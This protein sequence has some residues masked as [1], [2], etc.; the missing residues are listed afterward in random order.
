MSCSKLAPVLPL[1]LWGHAASLCDSAAALAALARTTRA[2]NRALASPRAWTAAR[3]RGEDE[4]RRW[5]EEHLGRLE[6]AI[7]A[8]PLLARVR[9]STEHALALC[10]T[11]NPASAERALERGLVEAAAAALAACA[12]EDALTYVHALR[13]LIDR[14]GDPVRLRMAAAGASGTAARKLE[15]ADPRARHAGAAL[16]ALAMPR[17]SDEEPGAPISEPVLESVLAAFER[18]DDWTRI[19]CALVLTRLAFSMPLEIVAGCDRLLSMLGSQA[20]PCTC[21]Q[22]LGCVRNSIL[23]TIVLAMLGDAEVRARA[24]RPPILRRM[25][26]TK[27]R[28]PGCPGAPQIRRAVRMMIDRADTELGE[29]MRREA[30][31]SSEMEALWAE[32]FAHPE[33]EAV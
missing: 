10:S 4:Q 22:A 32:W 29:Q 9:P 23:N 27:A 2:L 24:L 13:G 1:T 8:L 33:A 3:P 15:S 6:G 19:S 11:V 16:L 21:A 26:E 25:F 31:G 17:T 28:R 12:P 18:D 20:R 30:A 5:L 7:G 14:L